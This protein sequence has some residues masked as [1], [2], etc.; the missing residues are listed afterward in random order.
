MR[1]GF[2]MICRWLAAPRYNFF[3][4][5]LTPLALLDVVVLRHAIF[6]GLG[7]SGSD[8]ALIQQRSH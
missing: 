2:L 1:L 7:V 4:D 3:I 8:Q 5:T 6:L